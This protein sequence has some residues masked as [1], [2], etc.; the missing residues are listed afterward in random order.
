MEIEIT[1]N[2]IQTKLTLPNPKGR[3]V[4]KG[5]KLLFDAQKFDD[6]KEQLVKLEELMDYIDEMSSK[7]SGLSVDE[8]DDLDIDDKNKIVTFYS[9]KI[10]S[11]LDFL[12]SSLM[13]A[14]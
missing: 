2:N 10:F 3:E 4:K 8:L 11:R 1:K 14:N 9:E 12:K 13:R 6:E 5:L 7:N